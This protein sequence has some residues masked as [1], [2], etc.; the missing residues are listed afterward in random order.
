[1]RIVAG[2][3]TDRQ[4]KQA[5]AVLVITRKF[6]A[7]HPGQ[8]EELLQAQVRSNELIN[9]DEVVARAAFGTELAGLL[10]HAPSARQLAA[11]L[12]R[13]TFTN[14]PLAVSVFAQARH[15]AAASQLAPVES[16]TGLLDL[17]PLNQLL[18]TSGQVPVPA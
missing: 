13:F 9:T 14:N 18:P 11:S 6:L 1:M 15:A 5:T 17:Q 2:A 12:S 8:A 4:G 3:S 10:S 16:L 7:A